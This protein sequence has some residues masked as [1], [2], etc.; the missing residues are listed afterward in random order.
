[1][2]GVRG[3]AFTSASSA[4]SSSEPKA[5]GGSGRSWSGAASTHGFQ[6]RSG[7]PPGFVPVHSPGPVGTTPS[8]VASELSVRPRSM[9]RAPTRRPSS[10]PAAASLGYCTPACTRDGAAS[11]ARRSSSSASPGKR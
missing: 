5:G 2:R 9:A 8:H 11:W 6:A 4:A 1:M 10:S 3:K 7:T